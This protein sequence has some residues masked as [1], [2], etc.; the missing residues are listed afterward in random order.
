MPVLAQTL[1]LS[2]SLSIPAAAACVLREAFGQFTLNLDGLLTSDDPEVV[3]Q[4]RIGWRR[5]RCA[6]RIFKPALRV[7]D[8]PSWSALQ[9]LLKVLGELRDLDVAWHETLPPVQESFIAGDAR[10]MKAWQSMNQSLQQA[11]AQHRQAVRNMRANSEV[12]ATLVAITAWL[13]ALPDE[14]RESGHKVK[15]SLRHW[16]EHRISR[17]HRKLKRARKACRNSAQQHRLRILAKR[18]RYGIEALQSVLPQARATRWHQQA[19]HLQVQLGAKRDRC[20]VNALV[21]QLGL[22]REISD[23]LRGLL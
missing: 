14:S 2:P 3:H 19:R 13:E 5:F 6:L 16:S 12:D 20:Q 23:C 1:K 21:T 15:V 22:G 8:L 7:D 4:A 17:L 9:S 10:R 18:M 11:A